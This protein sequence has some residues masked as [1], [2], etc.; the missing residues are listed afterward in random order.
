MRILYVAPLTS[1]HS[2]RWIGFFRDRG[3]EIHVLSFAENEKPIEGV[4][5][6]LLIPKAKR[7]PQPIDW[8]LNKRP[9]FRAIRQT[10]D[11]IS[12]DIVHVHWID[13][14]AFAMVK[15]HVHP[16]VLTAWGSDVLIKTRE[17]A[18][19]R[20]VVRGAVRGADRITCDAEHMREALVSHGANR[21]KVDV[22]N[23]GT[24]CRLFNPARRDLGLA[25]ELGFPQGAPLVISLRGLKPVYDISTLIRAVPLVLAEVPEARFVVASDGPDRQSLEKAAADAGVAEMVRFTGY[26]SDDDLQR[27][28]ASATVYVSTSLSDGGI[29]ASTAEAMAAG[30]PAVVTAFGD[31]ADWVKDGETGYLFPCSDHR[32]LADR[33]VRLLRDEASCRAIGGKA[34]NLIL[35]RNNYETQMA[36]VEAMYRHC[37]AGGRR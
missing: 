17:S 20:Y 32:A 9:L 26:L 6:H 10:V 15:A 5:H 8:I 16:L 28:T 11:R 33:V 31:N 12:P 23:F 21:A 36:R 37:A 35:E 19:V 1:I 34:R 22:I 18:K 29:A 24:D 27:Y 4:Q 30:V 14:F 7:F 13:F 25:R 3:H 2:R